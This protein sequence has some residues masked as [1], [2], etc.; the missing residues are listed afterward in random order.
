MGDPRRQDARLAGAGAGEDEHRPVQRFDCLALFG[1]QTVKV[2]RGRR[3]GRHGAGRDAALA[4]PWGWRGLRHVVDGEGVGHRP[5]G[6]GQIGEVHE[7][8]P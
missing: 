1:V 7:S 6:I 2:A 3:G 8:F 5:S 4:W